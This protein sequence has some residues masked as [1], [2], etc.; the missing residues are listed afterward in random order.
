MKIGKRLNVG[1]KLDFEKELRFRI[2]YCQE[3]SMYNDIEV[4]INEDEIIKLRNHLNT[5]ID[6]IK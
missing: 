6:G 3:A 2:Q 4:H 1:D 5:I